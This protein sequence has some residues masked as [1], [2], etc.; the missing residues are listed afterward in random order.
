M[1][2]ALVP[3][4]ICG[5]VVQRMPALRDWGSLVGMFTFPVFLVVWSLLTVL[6]P[7]VERWVRESAVWRAALCSLP[8]LSISMYQ[9]LLLWEGHHL[10]P[11]GARPD[12]G[13]RKWILG[14]IGGDGRNLPW[15]LKWP[16]VSSA[17]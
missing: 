1:L 4:L 11:A 7:G 2:E 5:H 16:S 9:R 14:L 8:Y 10:L 13:A 15:H 6:A 3:L 12:H 17:R